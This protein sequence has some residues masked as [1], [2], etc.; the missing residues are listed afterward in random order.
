MQ[1][2]LHEGAVEDDHELVRE[3]PWVGG[4]CGT[5]PRS[6]SSDEALVNGQPRNSGAR[7]VAS[8]STKSCFSCSRGVP[9]ARSTGPV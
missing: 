4:S 5:C 7:M 1:Q 8:S 3:L 9:P 6:A 2:R